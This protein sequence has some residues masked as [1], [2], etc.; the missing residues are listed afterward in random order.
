MTI[1]RDSKRLLVGLA[2]FALALLVATG[3][4]TSVLAASR[5]SDDPQSTASQAPASRLG[6]HTYPG[7]SLSDAGLDDS[8]TYGTNAA[9]APPELG[10][11]DEL[12]W[13][14]WGPRISFCFSWWCRP[15]NPSGPVA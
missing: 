12:V 3:A 10:E 5:G 9:Q 4:I 7:Q 2:A 13:W 1:N 8:T 11:G 14:C 6:A 15:P